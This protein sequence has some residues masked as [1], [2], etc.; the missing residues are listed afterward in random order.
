VPSTGAAKPK[1]KRTPRKKRLHLGYWTDDLAAG[2][3]YA[4]AAKELKSDPNWQVTKQW[5]QAMGVYKRG[6]ANAAA[7]QRR[8]KRMKKACGVS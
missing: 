8:P 4:A 7:E 3:A 1:R 6:D 5:Q 2:R